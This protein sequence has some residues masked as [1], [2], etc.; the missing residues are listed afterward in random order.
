MDLD[1]EQLS[2]PLVFYHVVFF[3]CNDLFIFSLF[4]LYFVMEFDLFSVYR[5]IWRILLIQFKRSIGRTQF[6]LIFLRVRRI[7]VVTRRVVN[8]RSNRHTLIRIVMRMMKYRRLEL[9][10]DYCYRTSAI[11]SKRLRYRRASNS[12]SNQIQGQVKETT[13]VDISQAGCP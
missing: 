10:V 13:L 12:L 11:S 1:L 6:V 8:Q 4:W 7:T 2:F 9:R 3:I 5:R